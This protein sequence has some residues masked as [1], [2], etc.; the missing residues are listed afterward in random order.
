MTKIVKMKVS[1][2]GRVDNFDRKIL[3]DEP[4]MPLYEAIMNSIQAIGERKSSTSSEFCIIISVLPTALRQN[5]APRQLPVCFS[6]RPE[7]R[8]P[9]LL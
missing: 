8:L 3:Y 9:S 7:K 5:P 1:T 6:H 4:Y 2:V